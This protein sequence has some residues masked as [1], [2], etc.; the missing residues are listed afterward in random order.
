MIG[1]TL[2]MMLRRIGSALLAALLAAVGA[3]GMALLGTL[4]DKQYEALD[5]TYRDT[6][7]EGVIT[8]AAGSRRTGLTINAG[9]YDKLTKPPLD[10]LIRDIALERRSNVMTY[11]TLTYEASSEEESG[12]EGAAEPNTVTDRLDAALVGITFPDRASELSKFT[13]AAITYFD[14]FDETVFTSAD[15]VCF[16][17]DDLAECMSEIKGKPHISVF[18][19]TEVLKKDANGELNWD[20]ETTERIIQ[21]AGMVSGGRSGRLYVPYRWLTAWQRTVPEKVYAESCTFIVADNYRMDEIR[22]ALEKYFVVPD[23][24]MSG[25]DDS[26]GYKI[27]DE[28]FNASI[29]RI[30]DNIRLMKALVPS[31]Y[32][33]ASLIGFLVSFLMMRTRTREFAVMRSLGV[34]H[35]CVTAAACFEQTLLTL[36]GGAVG[37]AVLTLV[38]MGGKLAAG[39][40]FLA[41]YL[42]GSLVSAVW[43]TNVNVMKLL[44]SEE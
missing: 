21:V 39:C 3:V 15:D 26:F 11:T 19:S 24:R 22:A 9:T 29:K 6:V 35:A 28:V 34:K 41:C 23:P 18:Y 20:F 38:G 8:N 44:K 40:V 4:L 2:K 32:V 1:Y 7:I 12:E 14:G 42:F 31:L 5:R 17:S 36:L 16:I 10:E 25:D 43:I 33:A 27:L 37:A 30:N 13:G